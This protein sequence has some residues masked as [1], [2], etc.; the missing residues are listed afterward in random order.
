METDTKSSGVA[1]SS[2]SSEQQ[3]NI[4]LKTIK[5]L[6]F[7]VKKSDTITDLKALYRE[8]EGVSEHFQEIFFSGERLTDE[9]NLIDCG[10]QENSNLDLYIGYSGLLK[11]F[12]TI[13]SKQKT[14]EIE[15]K[16]KE[17]IGTIK[18][19]ICLKEG[20]SLSN[21]FS[22][23]HNGALLDD[24][25]TLASIGIAENSTL[26]LISNPRDSISVTIEFPA[27]NI[28]LYARVK[29]LFTVADLKAFL[30]CSYKDEILLYNG[31]ELEDSK[32]LAYYELNDDSVLTAEPFKLTIFVKIWDGRSITLAVER[33]DTGSSVK[34]E[35]F[36]KLRLR[37]N[38][39]HSL[40]FDGECLEDNRDLA[41]YGI[42]EL[43]TLHLGYNP[44]APNPQTKLPEIANL[45]DSQLKSTTVSE[46]M[47]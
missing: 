47:K 9:Q 29:I 25:R 38:E 21:Q 28:I 5:T 44:K 37:P 36:R 6:A 19:K 8:K 3:M 1:S 4:Y 41:S 15:A 26:N 14:V 31:K 12:I 2:P 35:V 7:K 33:K 46:M 24:F 45:D 11:L 34:R 43:S 18:S 13:I 30:G 32:T 39:H 17:T 27:E 42:K 22:L 40:T 20:I 16:I 10:V 23:Y